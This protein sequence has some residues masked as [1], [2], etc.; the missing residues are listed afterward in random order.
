M[1]WWSKGTFGIRCRLEGHLTLMRFRVLEK[2]GRKCIAGAV[3]A[4]GHALY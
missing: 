2:V 1:L 4:L 3:P